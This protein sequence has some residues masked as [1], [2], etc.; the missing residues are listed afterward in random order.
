MKCMSWTNDATVCLIM[1]DRLGMVER[2]WLNYDGERMLVEL[3]S[4][5]SRVSPVLN[6]DSKVSVYSRFAIVVSNSFVSR[7][8]PHL[9][10]HHTTCLTR[11]RRCP[12]R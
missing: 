7:Q 5:M 6:N 12:D 10:Q 2:F 11:K 8:D 3:R 9:S 1:V 4:W